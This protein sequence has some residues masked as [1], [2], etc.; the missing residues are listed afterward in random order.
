MPMILHGSGRLWQSPL[1][2][3]D[4]GVQFGAV[5]LR[6]GLHF[7]DPLDEPL[8]RVH[9]DAREHGLRDP[10]LDAGQLPEQVLDHHFDDAA[11]GHESFQSLEPLRVVGA[12]RRGRISKF[13]TAAAQW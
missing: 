8:R 11:S 7:Q 10:V 4:G 5:Q 13:Q 1:T 3:G 9:P 2:C 12:P 6:A